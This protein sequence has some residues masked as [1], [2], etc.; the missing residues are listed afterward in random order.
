M[1]GSEALKMKSRVRS[2]AQA[3]IEGLKAEGVTI[4]FGITG[5]AIMPVYDVLYDDDEIRHVTAGHEQGA[6]HAADGYARASGAV[7]VCMATS[8]P[9]ATNLVTGLAN[10]YMDSIPVV[11]L[12]GQVPTGLVGGDAFQEA[13]IRGITLPITKHNWMLR[14]PD[15]IPRTIQEGFYIARTGRPGPVLLDLPK[16]MTTGQTSAERPGRV[17]LE[18]YDPTYN[19]HP[20]QLAEAVEAI[21]DSRRPA[22]IAGGGVISSEASDELKELA[23]WLRIPVISTLM[24]LGAFPGDNPLFLGMLGMHGTGYANKA[25]THS[26]LLICIGT[27]F[28][29]RITGKVSTFAPEARVIHI[30]I[31]PSEI[32][33]NVAAHIPIVGDAKEILKSL[34]RATGGLDRPDTGPWLKQLG[35][36]KDKYPL[37]CDGSGTTLKP[38]YVIEELGGLAE[39]DAIITT[40]VGQH[41]MWVAQYYT[42]RRPRTLITSGGLGT[43]GFG[44]PAAIGAQ[45]AKPG[46]QVVC[47][48]GDGSFLMTIQEL[49][50]VVRERLP[51]TMLILNNR[52]LGM[53]R[54]WQQLFYNG[55]YAET[56]LR[57]GPR[58]DA[59][60]E[61]FGAKG[62]RVERPEEVRPA[63][64]EGLK[65][66]EG[67]TVIDFIVEEE[68]NVFPMVPAGASVKDF[69]VGEEHA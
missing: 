67:P 20:Q 65:N 52:H 15:D 46:R 36:W 56:S 69:M 5:G 22:I 41:Q 13:D 19:G 18:G 42:F 40:G 23:D 53:V 63:I 12:T 39:E 64:K 4:I 34:N 51:I 24:G 17:E 58:Y 9:G 2:G 10:A 31:D 44:L 54:Q 47:V 11:A 66:R 55:R 49:A 6:V 57:G 45:I 37:T 3:V 60:A 30:D 33:K 48:D 61:A 14:H 38:Q 35:K 26:D 32:G 28:D 27:R 21:R 1:S 62:T 50:T 29:D 43:M 16:D 68:E 7:G 25:V 59:V 8:G